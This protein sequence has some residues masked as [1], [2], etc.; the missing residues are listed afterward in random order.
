MARKL[1]N[2]EERQFLDSLEAAKDE[3]HWALKLAQKKDKPLNLA[4]ELEQWF[5]EEFPSGFGF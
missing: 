1:N 2:D 3:G 5:G 4:P